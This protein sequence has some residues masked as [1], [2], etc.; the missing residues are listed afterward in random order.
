VTYNAKGQWADVAH[1]LTVTDSGSKTLASASVAISGGFSAGDALHF[2][3]QS[4]ITGS[5]NASTGVLTLTGAASLAAYQ[6]ALE[7][8]TFSSSSANPTRSGADMT[9][10]VSFAVNDGAH[11][12]NVIVAS[13]AVVAQP[14]SLAHAGGALTYY[15][16]GAADDIAHALTV[17]S[18]GSTTLAS[19]SVSITGGFS[20]GDAL[21]FTNQSGITGSYNASTGVL[22][23]AGAATLAAYQSALESVT[24]S[25]SLTDP[26]KGGADAARTVSFSVNDGVHSSSSLATSLTVAAGSA[27]PPLLANTGAAT[28]FQ[29]NGAW[30]DVAHA[31]A[32]TDPG[33]STLASASVM[34]SGGFISGDALHFA[35]E[36]GISGSYNASTGVLSLAGTAS[37]A[38]YQAELDSITFSSSRQDPTRAGADPMRAVS[39]TV[40]D[41][42][43]ISNIVTA[44]VFVTDPVLHHTAQQLFG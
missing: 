25:S 44:D 2:A 1:A 38:A 26:T 4:G 22:T 13:V 10:A 15:A 39:F 40:N 28:T 5:Y 18:P 12:S 23:L 33:S 41:G 7:S 30:L 32:V 14:P 43:H 16:G 24:F 11:S 37:L 29:A 8:V 21:N 36:A 42:H 31:L 35:Q 17:T 34:I 20:T 19:A 3:N 27:P 6:T 9:R